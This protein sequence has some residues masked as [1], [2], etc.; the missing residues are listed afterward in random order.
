[1][2][3]DK[4]GF[5]LY[6]DLIHTIEQMPSDKAG[7]LFLHILRYVN[8]KDPQSNDLLVNLTFEPI[9]QQLKRDLEKWERNRQKKIEAGRKG[10][11]ATQSNAKQN[12][13]PLQSALAEQAELKHIQANQA[14]T[15]SVIS[16]SNSKSNSQCESNS[17]LI[18]G[19]AVH[20]DAI[21]SKQSSIDYLLADEEMIR[22]ATE[23]IKCEDWQTKLLLDRFI[24]TNKLGTEFSTESYGNIRMHFSRWIKTQDL[25]QKQSIKPKRPMGEGD[26][27]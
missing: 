9:K 13:A 14:V 7:E 5:I 23:L 24:N 22:A 27:W 15:V 11:Q 25:P 26:E 18:K 19:K 20:L 16:N 2:A 8:D 12:Q 4:K 21:H 3:E 6:A 17:I 10:G 1:M